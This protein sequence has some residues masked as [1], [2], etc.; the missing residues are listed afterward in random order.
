MLWRS[1]IPAARRGSVVVRACAD[2]GGAVAEVFF[3]FA[4][5]SAPVPQVS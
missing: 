2:E 5:E 3:E 1:S 4:A